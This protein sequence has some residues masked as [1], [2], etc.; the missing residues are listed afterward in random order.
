MT[1]FTDAY[2][3]Q[4][5]SIMSF[6]TLKPDTYISQWPGP[7]YVQLTCWA[8][9]HCLQ[10]WLIIVSCITRNKPLE[11]DWSFAKERWI[12][13]KLF[14]TG[15]RCKNICNMSAIYFPL[16]ISQ[17]QWQRTIHSIKIVICCL[18]LVP[19]SFLD[20]FYPLYSVGR[21]HSSN[22]ISLTPAKMLYLNHT[23]DSVDWNM[24]ASADLVELA[25]VFVSS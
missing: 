14:L 6:N 22:L 9:C 4:Q 19:S 15:N 25:K 1:Q 18:Q 8:P 2:M 11:H 24:F 7:F 3:R 16:F 20:H 17:W 10:Q 13:T 23:E 5:V 21:N 12:Q